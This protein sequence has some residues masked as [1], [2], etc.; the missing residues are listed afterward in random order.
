MTVRDRNKQLRS[1][2]TFPD[3]FEPQ[4]ILIYNLKFYAWHRDLKHRALLPQM[5]E[6]LKLI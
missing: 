6:T 2:D 1:E 3:P 5:N 4:I